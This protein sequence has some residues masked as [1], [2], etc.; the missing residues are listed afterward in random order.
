MAKEP[1]VAAKPG[2]RFE[3]ATPETLT[4]VLDSLPAALRPLHRAV[5][6]RI[7][8]PEQGQIKSSEVR[9]V[10]LLP[11]SPAAPAAAGEVLKSLRVQRVKALPDAHD[12]SGGLPPVGDQ[13]TQ[14][15]CVS[16]AIGYYMKSYQEA[17]ERGWSLTDPAHQFS[18]RFLYNQVS[19]PTYVGDVGST[20]PGNL[21]LLRDQG[22]ASLV[23]EPYNAADYT[24][25]P[26]AQSYYNAIPFRAQS[27]QYLGHGETDQVFETIRELVAAGELVAIGIPIFRPNWYSPGAWDQLSP[28]NDHYDLPSA[29]DVYLA[30][31]HAIPIVGYDINEFGGTGGFKI[32]NE[33]GAGWGNG[34][35]A[36][37]SQRF[38]NTYGLEF[39]RMV[40]RIGYVPQG[41]LHYKIQH[42]Y[43]WYDRVTVTV[44]V[45]PVSAPFWSKVLN[46]RLTRDGFT[47]DRWVDVT[48]G[49]GYLPP[50]FENRWWVSI[51]DSARE[52]ES[53][54]T[55][56]AL[57]HPGGTEEAVLTVPE[58]GPFFSGSIYYY[59]PEGA[60]TST[61]YYVNDAYDPTS[62]VYCDSEGSDA[63]DGLTP[64]APK[65][66]IQAIID[67][68]T[69]KAG[70]RV[71]IDSGA[72]SSTGV[73]AT[74]DHMDE[75]ESGNP[76]RFIGAV[77]QNGMVTTVLERTNAG[78]PVVSCASGFHFLQFENLWIRGGTAGFSTN[79][80]WGYG[81]DG[82]ALD[83]VVVSGASGNAIDLYETAGVELDS[84]QLYQFGGRGMQ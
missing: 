81:T 12:N 70:D 8:K 36:W 72:Y 7:S 58:K 60:G 37:I 64:A 75:G 56:L 18:P 24:T 47:W 69:L 82:L 39:Y 83:N 44:G 6:A 4:A 61:D 5:A 25:Y 80:D 19:Y 41:R 62:D 33:W 17:R 26:A 2:V 13:G 65:R 1:P 46:G 30:G 31:Y 51:S 43:W 14:N 48:E 20:F 16:W 57:E 9:P 3:T 11:S 52:D 27:Y 77:G 67:T 53:Y 21:D 74:L 50:D 54:T 22:C 63:N 23:D 71:W 84:C 55:I 66:T 78:G 32:V 29:E 59:L 73:V 40:D 42:N 34:G 15:S 49:A 45:G 68:Y 38:L 10:G 28:A 35:F 79:G 76:T